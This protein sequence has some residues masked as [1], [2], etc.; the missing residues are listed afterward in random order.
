MMVNVMIVK[1]AAHGSDGESQCV[2]K[3]VGGECTVNDCE[4]CL[5]ILYDDA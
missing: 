3:M 4:E 5:V 1:S 2:A